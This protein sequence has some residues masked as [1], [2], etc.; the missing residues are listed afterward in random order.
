MSS[1]LAQNLSANLST[2]LSA[3]GWRELHRVLAPYPPMTLRVI[4]AIHWHMHRSTQ[5]ET[6]CCRFQRVEIVDYHQEKIM[7]STEAERDMNSSRNLPDAPASVSTSSTRGVSMSVNIPT[8]MLASGMIAGRMNWK[9]ALFTVFLGNVLVLIP[10]LSQNPAGPVA[11]FKSREHRAWKSLAGETTCGSG[12]RGAVQEYSGGDR[13]P[14]R[15]YSA[16]TTVALGFVPQS[17]PPTAG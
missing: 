3:K 11:R 15:P 7:A 2:D 17:A 8:Y 10:M 6:A 14:G 12:C 1:S 16:L 4:G 13:A 5:P 9:Q